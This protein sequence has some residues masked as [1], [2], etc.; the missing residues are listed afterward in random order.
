MKN[1]HSPVAYSIVVPFYNEQENV[2]QLYVKIVDVMSAIGEPFEMI[3]VDDGSKDGTFRQ[4]SE[5]ARNDD[6]AV[7]VRL[8]RN[9]GQTAALKAGFDHSNGEIIISM[10]GDLQHDP[11]EIPRFIEKMQEGYD[12]VSG[13]RVTRT[14]HWLMRQIP[15]WT[16]NRMMA[17]LSRVDL[18]D[19]GT[20]F[21]AYRREI[22]SEIN[23]YGELHR[24][25][26][27]LASWAGASI[28][29][30]P[31][32]NIPRKNGKS[33]YGISRTIRVLLDLLSVK[34]L[35]DYSTRP[36]QLFGLAGLACLAFGGSVD[37]WLVIDKLAK[38]QDVMASHG[39]LLLLGT[40]LVIGG[41]QFLAIGL[42][43]ELLTRT[44]YESQDKPIYTVRELRGRRA[45]AAGRREPPRP[46]G[47]AGR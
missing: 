37:L 38:K 15:S 30:V 44:Y 4:L 12:I 28:G 39:P 17:W 29:E 3:F 20:T 8:R 36:L 47:T 23:L 35:L 1:E 45:V 41:I 6:R 34:F 26:P 22:L 2:P 33:N 7:V 40:A 10:D 24:F 9:F 46:A 43:G 5:I 19:F 18:H 27:A 21:K 42:I 32:T 13:W 31:I 25:I 16:A 11:A 14:D